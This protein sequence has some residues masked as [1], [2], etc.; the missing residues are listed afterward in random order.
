MGCRCTARACKLLPLGPDSIMLTGLF[1]TG[2][3]VSLIIVKIDCVVVEDCVVDEVI[4][5]ECECDRIA[6]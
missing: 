6:R 1:I 3:P 4:E 2:S 5:C